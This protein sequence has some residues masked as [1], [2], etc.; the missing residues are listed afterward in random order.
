MA[1]TILWIY[2]V[3]L[4]AGGVAGFLKAGSKV[5]LVTSVVFALALALF[6]AGLIAW[7]LGANLLLGIL[8][9]VFIVRYVKTRKFM[10]AGLL[11]LLTAVALLLRFVAGASA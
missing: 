2:I 8:L 5:S 3:L 11:I 4:I 10:P 9:V 6:A 7:P 1:N